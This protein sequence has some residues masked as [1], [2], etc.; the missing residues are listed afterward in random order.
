MNG[1]FF[2][3]E[4]LRIQLFAWPPYIVLTTILNYHLWGDNFNIIHVLIQLS[5]LFVVFNM[6]LPILYL[7]F[8]KRQAW[9]Q[10]LLYIIFIWL[11]CL[12]IYS[13][14]F[15]VLPSLGLYHL[16]PD[17]L[18]SQKK[19]FLRFINKYLSMFVMATALVL[20]VFNKLTTIKYLKEIEKRHQLEMEA[21]DLQTAQLMEQIFPHLTFNVL[22]DIKM[23]CENKIPQVVL[24]MQCISDL[25]RYGMVQVAQ[26]NTVVVVDREMDAIE[27]LLTLQRSRFDTCAVEYLV[28]GA[29]WGHKVPPTLL[30]TLIENAFKYGIK[31]DP[32]RPIHIELHLLDDRI[33]FICRNWIDDTAQ[34]KASTGQ[35]LT[36]CIQR[37]A[38]LFPGKY[39]FD[40]GTVN[41]TCYETKVVIMQL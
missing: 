31:N 40:F 32:E 36:N 15:Y 39:S 9:W 4:S 3:K 7:L 26:G 12:L 10:L 5:I 34:N 2:I 23:E 28:F 33:A 20:Q 35:G 41:R 21:K 22:N 19:G 6:T 37:L 11:L 30:L 16:D 8:R 1:T 17:F 29:S 24:Q 25:L 27:W 18:V 38:L 13:V 14:C